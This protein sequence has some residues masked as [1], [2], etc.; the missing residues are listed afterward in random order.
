MSIFLQGNKAAI[1]WN[2]KAE[3]EWFTFNRGKLETDNPKLIHVLRK[4]GYEEVQ[5]DIAKD[6]GVTVA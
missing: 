5:Q 3:K 6:L 4:H 2:P 1:L